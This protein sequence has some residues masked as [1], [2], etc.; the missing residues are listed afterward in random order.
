M[1]DQFETCPPPAPIYIVMV[2]FF[3]SF[4]NKLGRL[5]KEK[6]TLKG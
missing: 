6:K 2:D 1:Y 3:V 4:I 5:K